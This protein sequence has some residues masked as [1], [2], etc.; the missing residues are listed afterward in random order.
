MKL[1]YFRR[2]VALVVACGLGG[3]YSDRIW[4]ASHP[5]LENSLDKRLPERLE[6]RTPR[7]LNFERDGVFIRIFPQ[8][9]Q[10]TSASTTIFGIEKS[11]AV[12]QDSREK[13]RIA[14]NLNATLRGIRFLRID[15]TARYL[16]GP[17]GS[18]RPISISYERRHDCIPELSEFG[19]PFGGSDE[20]TIL[21]AADI[22]VAN[23]PINRPFSLTECFNFFYPPSLDQARPYEIVFGEILFPSGEREMLRV[24]FR[25]VYERDRRSY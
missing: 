17:A 11:S 4:L 12:L 25:P 13:K 21:S 3:C 8:V 1:A 20:I 19:Q 16:D 9:S 22:P 10:L 23:V 7:I 18:L 14:L 24:K 2:G 15:G 6:E 5:T